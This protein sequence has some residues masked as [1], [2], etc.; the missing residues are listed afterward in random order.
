MSK[1][2]KWSVVPTAQDIAAFTGMHCARL[3][4]QTL[5]SGWR[6]PCCGRSAVELIR[7]AAIRGPSWRQRYGDEYGMGWTISIT[8]HHCHGARRFPETTICGDCNSAD[9]AAKRVLTL[10][11]HWSFTPDEIGQFTKL[12]AHSGRTIIDYAKAQSIYDAMN[13]PL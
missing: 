8:R 10:P 12:T 1:I 3:Y 7:W 9:G 5:A 4:G 13:N 6:C 2:G 11:A